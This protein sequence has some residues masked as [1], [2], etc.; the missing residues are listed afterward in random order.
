MKRIIHLVILLSFIIQTV[1]L[2]PVF[3]LTYKNQNSHGSASIFNA[4]TTVTM[5]VNET[6]LPSAQSGTRIC[7]AAVYE[8]VSALSEARSNPSF[9]STDYFKP[10]CKQ[11][12]ISLLVVSRK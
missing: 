7:S 1:F 3:A 12:T 4:S 10:S 11:H 8:L 6:R 5:P 2:S 9:L